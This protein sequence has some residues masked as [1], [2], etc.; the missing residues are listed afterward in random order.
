M[1]KNRFKLN[2]FFLSFILFFHSPI[3]SEIMMLTGCKNIKDGFIKNEYILDLNKSIM[4]RNYI[5]NKETYKKYRIT[6]LSVKR[7]NSIER[8][9]YK[10]KNLILTDRVGYPQF[11]TQL[12]FEKNNTDIRIKTV[13]NDEEGISKISSCDKVEVF[14]KES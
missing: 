5:Y 8:F 11:Y 13:I 9:I 6:D 10:E 2:I 3:Y 1:S 7:E 4:V 12:I 14:E